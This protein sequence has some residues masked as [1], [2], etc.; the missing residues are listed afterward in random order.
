VRTSL[1]N[2]CDVL[3]F[4][5]DQFPELAQSGEPVVRDILRDG[6]ALIGSM[7]RTRTV[8]PDGQR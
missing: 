8:P 4:T 1:G 3:V 6:L 7:P 2:G 5:P